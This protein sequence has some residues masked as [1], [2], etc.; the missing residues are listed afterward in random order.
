MKFN[1]VEVLSKFVSHISSWTPAGV[2]NW[3]IWYDSS[4]WQFKW[5]T[6]S[7]VV[8]LQAIFIWP[9]YSND[10]W[11]VRFDGIT[12]DLVQDSLASI[13]DTGTLTAP[14]MV[15]NAN[16]A[17]A[18]QISGWIRLYWWANNVIVD[19]SSNEWIK[20]VSMPSAINEISIT[21]AA[22][23]NMPKIESSGWDTNIDLYI[24]WK[25]TWYVRVIRPRLTYAINTQTWTAYTLVASDQTVPVE[26]DNASANTVTIP[27]NASVAFPIGT[28]IMIVQIWA[29]LTTVQGATWVTVNWV[30]AWS[31]ATTGQY[32]AIC[33]YKRGTDEW[34]AVN[35]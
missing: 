6:A 26:M 18:M 29:W 21:N 27:A 8:T 14:A 9:G 2:V 23:F 12:G 5:Q 34:V 33:I 1:I 30:S 3:Q 17:T 4:I 24:S 20:F 19:W 35:K 11:I 32:Q 31:K 25:W 13:S 22:I 10:N 16:S 15:V 28:T 7:G